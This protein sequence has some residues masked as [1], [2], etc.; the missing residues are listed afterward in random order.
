VLALAAVPLLAQPPERLNLKQLVAEALARNPEVLAAQKRYE[1]AAQRPRAAS[2]LPDPMLSL[3]YQGVGAPLPGAGLGSEPMAN[4]GLMFTQEFPYPGKRDLRVKMASKEAQAE[5]ERYQLAQLNIIA[6]LKQAYYRLQHTYSILDLLGRNQQVLSRMLSVAESRYS[7]G[8]AQQPD[9][10]RTQTQL[11]MLEARRVQFE[12]E[13]RAAEAQLNTA[14]NRAL[15]TPVPRPS[16]PEVHEKLPLL[17]EILAAAQENSP[18]ITRDRRTIERNELAVNSARKEFYPDFALS[19]GYY[20]MGSM[21]PAYMFRADVRLP[22]WRTKQR[23]GVTEAANTLAESRRTYQASQNDIAYRIKE[24]YLLAE[25]SAKLMDIYSS[26][27]VPQSNL[28]LESALAGYQT[29]TGEFMSV[30]QS[31]ISS[32]EY[33][34]NYHEEMLN[35]HLA[36][37]RMEEL[38]GMPLTHVEDAQ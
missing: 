8:K 34:M 38:S 16:D 2:A 29:G 18:V 21:P 10:F 12:R 23:A 33:E 22:L 25:A 3:G 26:T 5:W 36:L 15:E 1:A 31:F 11:S 32:V 13:I 19:G 37:T 4:I 28:A 14:L 6:T 30:L 24:D 27:I 17:E 7:V 35:F 9:I 20:N